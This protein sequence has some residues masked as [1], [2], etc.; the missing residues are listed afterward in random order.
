MI[1]TE[2]TRSALQ[3]LVAQELQSLGFPAQHFA[4]RTSYLT[5]S[6]LDLAIELVWPIKV[7]F[8]GRPTGVIQIGRKSRIWNPETRCVIVNGRVMS[9]DRLREVVNDWC[10]TMGAM[11]RTAVEKRRGE[12]PRE[13][14]RFTATRSVTVNDMR[15]KPG[16][17]SVSGAPITKRNR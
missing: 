7:G 17:I 9:G 12:W 5:F 16:T 15:E 10:R 8:S 3:R 14:P 6:P 1:S 4:I 13:W 11:A 2:E